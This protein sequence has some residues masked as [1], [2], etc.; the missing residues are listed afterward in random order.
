MLQIGVD[1]PIYPHMNINAL[2]CFW[3]Y[4]KCGHTNVNDVG[5]WAGGVSEAHVLELQA[6]LQVVRGL[7]AVRGRSMFSVQVLE[8]LLR[9]SQ[10]PHQ[11]GV[12]FHNG[13]QGGRHKDIKEDIVII[14][15]PI[16]ATYYCIWEGRL[17]DA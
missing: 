14:K 4:L 17:Y 8:D 7:L 9:G 13:L 2:H 11:G 5:S 16:I 6:S 10:H 3:L 15:R 1:L 12:R